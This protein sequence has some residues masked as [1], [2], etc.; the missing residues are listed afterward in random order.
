MERFLYRLG[1][2]QYRG[3][4]VLK[5][6]MLYLLWDR[7]PH[8]PT[9]DLD[10]HGTGDC[11][12][13]HMEMVIKEICGLEVEDDGV[14]FL[15]ETVRGEEIREGQEYAG[16][17][18]QLVARLASARMSLQIDVGSG[19]DV[20]P[21]PREA[22]YPTVLSFQAPRIRVYPRESVVAEKYHALVFLGIANS[23]MK[24]FFDL[25]TLAKIFAFEG[26]MLARSIEVTFMRRRTEVPLRIP[27]GLSD[28]FCDD[29]G[30]QAQWRAFLSKGRLV[31]EE[32]SLRE[33]AEFLRTFLMPPSTAIARN[34]R[35]GYHWPAAGPWR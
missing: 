31:E 22:D 17:R 34:N 29:A 1:N 26:E 9:R 12:V 3:K 32:V 20:Y 13:A 24:D 6:A 14:V 33:V 30:K 2:S 8:R 18:L 16:V 11:S 21:E 25:W 10:L 7:A 23:R 19:D 35:F 27:M 4:F 28:E 15:Q 5:G